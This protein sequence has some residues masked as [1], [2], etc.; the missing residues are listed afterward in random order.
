MEKINISIPVKPVLEENK[1]TQGVKLF[2][3]PETN[4]LSS[5]GA[6]RERESR[7]RLNDLAKDRSFASVDM[8]SS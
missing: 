7:L 2:F 3:P 6:K 4:L 1:P 5:S 8:S